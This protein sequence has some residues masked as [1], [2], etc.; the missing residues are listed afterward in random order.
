MLRYLFLLSILF[1]ILSTK[2]LLSPS[3][4]EG[5]LLPPEPSERP[6][7]FT[8]SSISLQLLVMNLEHR[9]RALL[10]AIFRWF[11]FRHSVVTEVV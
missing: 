6:L 8:P 10:L 9:L 5:A 11:A 3:L 2:L 1:A 7:L 4:G